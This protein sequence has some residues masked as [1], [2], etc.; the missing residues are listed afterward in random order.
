M[1][2]I[3]RKMGG[4]LRRVVFDPALYAT[5]LLAAAISIPG[6]EG[7]LR[8]VASGVGSALAQIGIALLGVVLAALA[9]LV[10]FLHEEYIE[11]LEQLEPGIQGDLFPFQYTAFIA[12]ACAASGV[13]LL[14][15]GQPSNTLVLRV[16]FFAAIWVFLYL[17][18]I[19]CQLVQFLTI[20]ARV[21]VK[22][23]QLRRGKLQNTA[24]VD[25]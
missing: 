2:A 22:Q 3:D 24:K 6:D 8:A 7:G 1:K 25:C 14:A 16:T 23:I 20:H 9:V 18:I 10:V 4:H 19:T 12:S 5:L 11:L 21:R 13:A 15:L 17:L